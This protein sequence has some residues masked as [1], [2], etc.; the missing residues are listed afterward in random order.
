[1]SN[2]QLFSKS[3]NAG[4]PINANSIVK[5]GAND[6]DVLQAAAAADKVLGVT[7]EIA[8]STGERCDVVLQGIVDVKLGGTVTRGDPI[9]SDA[10][11][12]GVTA[13]PSAG[14]NNRLV[15]FA[16]ISGVV[17]DIIPVY[18]AQGSLQG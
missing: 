4:G 2:N 15:G 16:I 12:N 18:L 8:A 9:T 7:T 14:T 3:F 10:S 17:G 13:A 5:A 6:Y 11:G 1:M